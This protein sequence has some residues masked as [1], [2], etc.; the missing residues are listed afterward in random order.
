MSKTKSQSDNLLSEEDVLRTFK[1]GWDAFKNVAL[2]KSVPPTNP[3]PVPPQEPEPQRI[4]PDD[5]DD[6]NALVTIGT[7][8]LR[9][10]KNEVRVVL[11]LEHLELKNYYLVKGGGGRLVDALDDAEVDAIKHG[12]T[13]KMFKLVFLGN[14]FT[15]SKMLNAPAGM[16]RAVLINAPSS[17]VDL[18]LK[19]STADE[20][21]PLLKKLF[22]HNLYLMTLN[23]K[24]AKQPEL[25]AELS[26][27]TPAAER[28]EHFNPHVLENY[29][30]YVRY[31]SAIGE[32]ANR[33]KESSPESKEERRVSDLERKAEFSTREK[34]A[35]DVMQGAVSNTQF[36]TDI[37]I[38]AQNAEKA[39]SALLGAVASKR[40]SRIE[41]DRILLSLKTG[42]PLLKSQEVLDEVRK[43]TAEA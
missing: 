27:K 24:K 19:T 10:D 28:A 30:N 18:L 15:Y 32:Y 34:N 7:E 20:A 8:L 42:S 12:G 9:V 31:M 11:Y 6:E 4:K 1:R 41:L 40:L 3:V 35:R 43:K 21:R 38:G 33:Q 29:P 13:I 26:A 39:A 25:V 22:S 5:L 14:S 37:L 2:K 36:V 16:D 23:L 17:L